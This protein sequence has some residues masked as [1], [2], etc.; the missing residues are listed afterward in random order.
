MKNTLKRLGALL[1]AAIMMIAMCV[2]VMAADPTTTSK[3]LPVTTNNPTTTDLNNKNTLNYPTAADSA[4]ITVNGFKDD[5]VDAN[6]VYAYRIV[7]AQYDQKGQVGFSGYIAMVDVFADQEEPITPLFDADGNPIYP[8][9]AQISALAE[10]TDITNQAESGND[11]G[12]YKMAKGTPAEGKV[13]FT[14]TVPVGEYLVLAKSKD[15]ETVYNPMVVSVY[16]TV[17]ENGNEVVAT[18]AIS[19]D[20]WWGLEVV[21][22]YVKT[23]TPTVEKEIVGNSR[24]NPAQDSGNHGDD[25]AIGDTVDFKITSMIPSYSAMFENKDSVMTTE[26][27]IVYNITDTMEAGLTYL[28]GVVDTNGDGTADSATETYAITIKPELFTD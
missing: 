20:E 7:K 16:Y 10:N 27:P 23:S 24:E 4:V 14:A 8:T 13:A 2:P 15:Q 5:Q 19:A 25:H 28:N 12:K 18:K 6:N 22:A 1:I 3:A 26:Q 17:D 11:I 21:D 9:A